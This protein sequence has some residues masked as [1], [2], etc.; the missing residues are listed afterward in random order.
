MRI[1]FMDLESTFGPVGTL[2]WGISITIRKKGSA[3]TD[4][5][6]ERS[7]EAFG[8]IIRSTDL[9]SI[10][11]LIA[12][13]TTGTIV[14]INQTGSEFMCGPMATFTKASGK[15]DHGVGLG[16]LSGQKTMRI[17]LA[18]LRII[19]CKAKDH[20]STRMALTTKG[21]LLRTRGMD[22]GRVYG[23]TSL[24]ILAFGA[25]VKKMD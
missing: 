21:T 1:R 4:G 25:M 24:C 18:T 8:T 15:T 23:L 6:M 17:T 9:G 22:T 19:I 12:A 7:I 10:D 20:T 14:M 13:T 16:I 5:A 11:T 2:T 3:F